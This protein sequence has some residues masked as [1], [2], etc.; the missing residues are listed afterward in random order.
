MEFLLHCTGGGDPCHTGNA[1]QFVHQSFIEKIRQ[2]HGIHSLFGHRRH[3]DRQHRGVDFQHIR[4][5]H[6]VI[7]SGLQGGDRLL[8]IHADGV[9][10]HRLLK[11]QHHHA[12]ILT[13]GG[14]HLH[15]VLQS[16]HGLFQGPGDL[17]FHLFGTRS[18]IS[19]HDHHIGK[20]HIRKQVRC[21]TQ[22]CHNT[23]DQHSNHR[24]KNRHRFFYRKLDHTFLL[25]ADTPA[26]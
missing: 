8:D 9:H 17:C 2:L 23:Q 11:F 25:T 1:F 20:I 13:G 3:G 22:I 21:H 7:P 15:N 6:H 4:R 26:L 14:G 5:T 18:G 24:N 16:G 19:G 12:V 10:V